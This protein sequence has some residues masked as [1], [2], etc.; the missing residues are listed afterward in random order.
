MS[1]NIEVEGGKSIR[2]PTAG[3]YCDRDIVV[4][5]TGSGGGGDDLWQYVYSL[6]T[7]FKN[8]IFPEDYELVMNLP[9]VATITYL[10]QDAQNLK[11]LTM[12]GGDSTVAIG[13][14]YCFTNGTVEEIDLSNFRQGGICFAASA[15]YPFY[16]CSRLKYIRGEIDM[17]LVTSSL[18]YFYSCGQLVEVRFKKE[19]I[20][21][22][23]SITSANLSDASIESIIDG[24]A[25]ITGQSTKPTLTLRNSVGIKLTDAQKARI[26]DKGWILAY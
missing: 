24:L 13:G 6:N 9:F 1:F 15:K 25:Y 10:I 16:S 2:L 18:N 3:K 17:S 14:T 23:L 8:A 11:K 12:Y 20:F 4:T 21:V 19:T 26:T 5:A 7:C 22:D